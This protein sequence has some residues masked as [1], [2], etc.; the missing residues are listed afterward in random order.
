MVIGPIASTPSRTIHRMLLEAGI[1]II[2][3][4]ANL[5]KVLMREKVAR[6][7]FILAPLPVRG[8]EASPCRVISVRS[9][10]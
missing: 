10:L 5:D 4:V 6:S 8:A 9:E 2:E 7:F 3:K 1:L